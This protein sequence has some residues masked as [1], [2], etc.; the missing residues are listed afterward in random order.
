ME[1]MQFCIFVKGTLKIAQGDDE[2]GPAACSI[3]QA[4]FAPHTALA[5][6]H[7]VGRTS[8]EYVWAY[9]PGVPLLAPG[10]VITPEFIAACTALAACGTHLHHTGLGGGS[11]LDVLP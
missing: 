5:L 6:Q 9:P 3:A 1:L 8:A 7:A 10:E 11:T 4:L 2:A